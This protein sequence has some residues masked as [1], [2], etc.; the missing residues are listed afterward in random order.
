MTSITPLNVA[1]ESLASNPTGRPAVMLVV[2]ALIMILF[3]AI[4]VAGT[5]LAG[6]LRAAIA[7]TVVTFAVAVIPV[8]LLA[9]LFVAATQ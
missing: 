4:K 9:L 7:A 2:L 1:R 8:V 5:A 6:L 3:W